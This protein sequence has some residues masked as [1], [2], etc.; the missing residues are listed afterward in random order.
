M[1]IESVRHKALKAFLESGKPRGID[2]RVADRL[3]FC[4]LRAVKMNFAYHPISA[5]IG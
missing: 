4:L 1:E 5:F 2:A 3:R